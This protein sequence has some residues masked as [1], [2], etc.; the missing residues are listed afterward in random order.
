MGKR[1][2]T[3]AKW[4]FVVLCALGILWFCMP[5]LHG[6]FGEGSAFG[7]G[8]CGMGIVL[9]VWAPKWARRGG[10]RRALCTAWAALYI[11]GLGWAGYL[12]GLILSFQAAE[13]PGNLNVVVLGAQVYSA[14]RMGMSL[15]N[16]VAR[17]RDYLEEYPQTACIVTG[18]MGGNEPCPE[19]LA[20][21]N[22]LV[23][24]GIAPDRIY[25]EDKSRNTRQNLEFAMELAK[26][27]GLDTRVVVVSQNFHLYRAVR[28]AR[29]AGF[30]AYG[31][32]AETDPIIFPSYYGRELLSLTKW[33]LE[34]LLQAAGGPSQ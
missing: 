34:E 20:A 24:G 5:V 7:V 4:A 25:M 18:G 32:P 8:V 3:A 15:T 23:R 1:I 22:A 21:K 2:R 26:K 11:L 6:G 16:R 27:E 13:P 30:E 19:S 10:W 31:L 17:A 29:A 28:L 12:T 9:A 14:E 33:Y